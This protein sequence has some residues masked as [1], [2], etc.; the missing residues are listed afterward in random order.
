MVPTLSILVAIYAVARLV[1]EPMAMYAPGSARWIFAT[2]VSAIAIVGIGFCAM[3]IVLS[4]A[5]ITALPGI[6]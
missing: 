1:Q 4:G 3:D 5:R 2:I 6:P